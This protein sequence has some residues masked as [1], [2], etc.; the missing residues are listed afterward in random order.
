MKVTKNQLKQLISEEIKN[1]LSESR[2]GM[3][4]MER[5]MDMYG[6]YLRRQ[7]EKEQAQK[8]AQQ[9]TPPPADSTDKADDDQDEAKSPADKIHDLAKDLDH[10]KERHK[11]PNAP[12]SLFYGDIKKS[13]ESTL[14]NNGPNEYTDK[15]NNRAEGPVIG[16]RVKW[17]NVDAGNDVG[18]EGIAEASPEE[19]A[20]MKDY[21]MP[22]PPEKF[23]GEDWTPEMV[24]IAAGERTPTQKINLITGYVGDLEDGKKLITLVTA[25]P[26]RGDVPLDRRDF[27]KE[28]LYF[29]LPETSPLLTGE[30]SEDT[31]DEA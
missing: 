30:E 3:P 21:R 2:Y 29:V 18:E 17:I 5:E 6:D 28:G 14:K 11:D 10:I 8:A 1:V 20:G 27:A 26:G 4:G 23:K 7:R 24:K 19:V 15:E 16:G 22:D 13:I 12:G 25:F 9:K 31:E